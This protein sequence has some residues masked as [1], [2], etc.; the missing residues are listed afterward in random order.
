MSTRVIRVTLCLL[1]LLAAF[2][3]LTSAANVTYSN[4]ANFYG[5]VP[6]VACGPFGG[7][8]GAAEAENSFIFLNTYYSGV[9]NPT[10]VTIG[11]NAAGQFA[12]AAMDFGLGTVALNGICGYYNQFGAGPNQCGVNQGVN[13]NYVNTLNAWMTAFAP[14]TTSVV[15]DFNGNMGGNLLTT[16]LG[17]QLQSHEDVELFIYS[18]DNTGNPLNTGHVIS[19]TSITYDPANTANPISMTYQDPNFPT[20]SYTVAPTINGAG[21]LSFTDPASG[22]GTV[23]ITAAFAESPLAS[24]LPEPGTLTLL[25]G[26][27][28]VLGIVGRRRALRT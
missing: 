18:L 13:Q 2:A 8:C 23:G 22:L 10:N 1:A 4:P 7:I 5:T 14:G 17:P 3:P 11:Q 15:S 24:A 20:N 21:Y 6:N 16:F 19:P 27:L 9:Y 25:G 12:Q 26:A 28:V